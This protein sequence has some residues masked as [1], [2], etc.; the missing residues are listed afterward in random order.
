MKHV[1][2]NPDGR[3]VEDPRLNRDM[4]QTTTFLLCVPCY[5]L[6][7][8][9]Y[10]TSINFNKR[11]YFY[12]SSPPNATPVATENLGAIFK[13]VFSKI[14]GYSNSEKQLGISTFFFRDS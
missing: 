12:V 14:G 4:E 8:L 2:W 6:C 11:K 1:T 10:Y 7:D 3:A 5:V 13:R 9:F